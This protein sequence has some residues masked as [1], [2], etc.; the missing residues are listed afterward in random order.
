MALLRDA[1]ICSRLTVIGETRYDPEYAAALAT[2]AARCRVDLELAG[3]VTDQRLQEV[4]E[5]SHVFTFVNIDQSWGLA[6]FEAMGMSLPVVLSD[7]VGAVELL[8]SSAGVIVVN[9][10]SATDIAGAL[11]A[12]TT[13]QTKY[14][15]YSGAAFHDVQD[16]TWDRLYS[17][18]MRNAFAGVSLA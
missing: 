17:S 2:H 18:R 13:D 5:R 1:G 12:I 15:A 14:D 8:R 4:L 3:Q 11:R 9:P 6:V 16:Y 10:T 7:S